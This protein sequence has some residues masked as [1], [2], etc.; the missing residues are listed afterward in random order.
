[1]KSIDVRDR[2]LMHG[3]TLDFLTTD[4]DVEEGADV[5]AGADIEA[6]ADVEAEENIEAKADVEAETAAVP[7]IADTVV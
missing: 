6:K 1:M 3:Q 4:A 7:M 2:E 5:E